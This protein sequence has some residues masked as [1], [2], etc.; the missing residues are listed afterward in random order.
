M[1]VKHMKPSP[2]STCCDGDG[3]LTRSMKLHS[4]FLTLT[5]MVSSKSYYNCAPQ[6]VFNVLNIDCEERF[7][8]AIFIA[9]SAIFN[10]NSD[11]FITQE[12]IDVQAPL[13]RSHPK[14]WNPTTTD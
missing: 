11:G 6:F 14:F 9:G 5:S 13:I 12:E 1:A 7:A 10:T 3:K 4:I 2:C 8:R